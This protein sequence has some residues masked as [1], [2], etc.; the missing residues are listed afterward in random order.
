MINSVG[1]GASKDLSSN[2]STGSYQLIHR[3]H[4]CHHL[5]LYSAQSEQLIGCLVCNYKQGP[6]PL[7]APSLVNQGMNMYEGK[8]NL[9]EYMCLAQ[10]W[11]DS[12][13]SKQDFFFFK[14]ECHS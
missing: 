6:S 14:P 7:Q 1:W 12:K 2:L 4:E 11:A 9:Y 3:V 10:C 5:G 8:M 13:Y